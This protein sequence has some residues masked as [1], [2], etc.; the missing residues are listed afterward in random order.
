[1]ARQFNFTC[2]YLIYKHYG[3]AFGNGTW[4]DGLAQVIQEGKVHIVATNMWQVPEMYK[5][6]DFG[7]TFN[8]V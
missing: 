2:T 7:P 3:R 8:K 5:L 1:M 6:V 4:R